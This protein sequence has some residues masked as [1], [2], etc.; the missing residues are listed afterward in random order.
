MA[1][2]GVTYTFVNG[3]ATDATKM[4]TNFTDVL[5]AMSDGTDDLNIAA[6]TCAGTATFNAAVNLGNAT[7]DDITISGSLASDIPIKTT[8]SY[9][10]GSATL[11]LQAIYL[12]DNAKT[13]ALKANPAA[14]ASYSFTYPAALGSL[15]Q[16]MTLDSSGYLQWVNPVT[17]RSATHTADGTFTAPSGVSAV[18]VYGCGGGAGG[19]GVGSSRGGVG[20]GGAGRGGAGIAVT[21]G[22]GFSVVVGGGGAGGAA[23]AKGT[24]GDP[25]RLSSLCTFFGATGGMD[26]DWTDY[27]YWY[28]IFDNG[29]GAGEGGQG[30]GACVLSTTAGYEGA[31]SSRFAGGTGGAP[32]GGYGGGGGG[33]GGGFGAGG[34][35]NNGNA[36]GVA[37]G[38]N[39]GGGGGGGKAGGAGGS[40]QIVIV[41]AE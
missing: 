9:D 40:G 16:Y 34:N 21:P 30:G 1:T 36:N 32:S 6:I 23:G 17:L 13:V 37:A 11:G 3:T 10:I 2:P 18:L 24:D 33:G 25:S 26:G 20:G 41:W 8:E 39:T 12:G 5:N 27:G 15:N 31:P 14:S 4:N 7:T 22:D 19:G 29:T 35:G 28:A 38:A